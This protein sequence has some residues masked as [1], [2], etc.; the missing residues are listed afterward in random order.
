[1]DELNLYDDLDDFQE[2]QEKVKEIQLVGKNHKYSY[3]ILFI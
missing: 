2:Q 1:M 3:E